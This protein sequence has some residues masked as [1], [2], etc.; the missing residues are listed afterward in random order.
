VDNDTGVTQGTGVQPSCDAHSLWTEE[1]SAV[2]VRDLSARCL[3]RLVPRD[4][5]SAYAELR[6][7]LSLGNAIIRLMHALAV[8]L[9]IL[10]GVATLIGLACAFMTVHTVNRARRRQAYATKDPAYQRK[11]LPM[12]AGHSWL[13][14]P[15]NEWTDIDRLQADLEK[16]RVTQEMEDQVI[17]MLL[18]PLADTRWASAGAWLLGIGVIASTTGATLALYLPA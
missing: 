12:N 1:S 5:G 9:T 15:E 2:H 7:A 13:Q 8:V 17:K 10:G 4:P 3:T 6:R 11:Q 18:Q 14:K 16:L